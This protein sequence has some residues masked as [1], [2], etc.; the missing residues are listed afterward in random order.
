MVS[1]VGTTAP[2]GTP[3][4]AIDGMS[5]ALEKAVATDELK[6]FFEKQAQT[7]QFMKGEAYRQKLDA[8]FKA[9]EP[10]AKAAAPP[11]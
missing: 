3:Q 8:V 5:S 1:G 10:V 9:I 6:T 4:E 2:K 7:G 11:N